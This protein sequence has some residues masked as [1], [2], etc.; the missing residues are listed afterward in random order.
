MTLSVNLVNSK[1]QKNKPTMIWDGTHYWEK[2]VNRE[3]GMYI[4]TNQTTGEKK[5]V[6]LNTVVR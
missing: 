2:E 1:L 5:Y 3:S 4:F 6:S